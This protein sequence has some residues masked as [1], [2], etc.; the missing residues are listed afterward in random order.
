M[1]A[2]SRARAFVRRCFHRQRAEADLDAEL[3]AY[4]DLLVDRYVERGL[5]IDEAR[6]SA[7]L[8]LE[9]LEQVKEQVRD[10]LSGAAI[11]SVLQDLRYA[12]RA[13]VKNP[14]FA[15]VALLTLALGIGVNTAIFSVVYAVLLR[16]LPYDHPERLILIWSTFQS[17]GSRA[18]TS[19]LILREVAQR[20]RVFEDVAG[21]WM[22]DGTFTGD[23]NPEQVRVGFVTPNF[24]QVLGVRPERG[25]LFEPNELFGGRPVL[26]LSYGLWQRRFGGDPGIVG[27][28][29][30]FQ[31]A[32]ATVVGV[33][34]PD[35][36]LHFATDSGL[37]PDIQVFAP[38]G[39]DIYRG[40][41]T[42]Y[43]LRLV[44]RLKPGLSLARAQEDMDSA[45]AQI[46]RSYIEFANENLK[47][48]VTPLHG[49]SVRD[50]RAALMALF[51]GA[52]FVL[53]IC[54][55][56]VANLLLARAN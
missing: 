23:L 54:C 42:L 16:P 41:R 7:R 25:R 3:R 15:V 13:L 32:S 36:A 6:R 43:Y 4:R 1:Y 49:D 47:F 11:D 28:G 8:E 12:S 39:Y 21:I 17:A 53:L 40:P 35:F 26:I 51:A 10:V 30:A 52:G 46:R 50:I 18:P 29:I 2:L 24:L 44:A 31:G 27:R 56:N 48:D 33:L 55:V 9:G 20:N 45:A 37:S 34:R 14:G 38:F 22:G 5:P 19:G